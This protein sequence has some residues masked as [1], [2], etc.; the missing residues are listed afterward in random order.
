VH[1]SEGILPTAVW[2]GG[3]A[4]G[5]SVVAFTL[6]RFDDRDIPR[7]G[8]LTSL[9]FVVSLIHVPFGVGSAHFQ[10]TALLGIVL[11]RLAWPAALVALFLQ[12]I[13]F[14]HGALTSLGVNTVIMG[15]G[16]TV[17]FLVFRG[18]RGR[19]GTSRRA[20]IA[21]FVATLIGFLGSSAVYFTAMSLGSSELGEVAKYVLVVLSPVAIVEALITAATVS[22]IVRVQPELLGHAPKVKA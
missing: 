8:V 10:L 20:A 7:V 18:L 13:L 12:A 21:A 19:D 4:L 22:F 3:H 1:I 17:S 14:S 6:G 9:F 5:G 15:A 2:A 11:G 16:A